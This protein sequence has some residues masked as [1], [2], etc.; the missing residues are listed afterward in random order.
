MS[1]NDANL[2]LSGQVHALLKDQY[3]FI[4]YENVGP[5]VVTVIGR[6]YT[7]RGLTSTSAIAFKWVGIG[8]NA[9]GEA[10][11]DTSLG[12]ECVSLG[13]SRTSCIPTITTVTSNNDTAQ[14]IVTFTFTGN[15]N[16]S[17]SGVFNN[18]TFP[19]GN[20][21]CRKTFAVIPCQNGDQLTITWKVTASSS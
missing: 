4:K 9:G 5:N 21:L 1:A 18:S 10:T 13:G 14:F 17:E 8:T 3:G 20:I 15:L 7:V 6:E 16:V 12:S 19:S 11:T 2:G